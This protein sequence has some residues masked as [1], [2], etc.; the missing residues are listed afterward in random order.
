MR[1]SLLLIYRVFAFVAPDDC[2]QEGDQEEEELSLLQLKARRIEPTAGPV[3]PGA[4]LL[5]FWQGVFQTRCQVDW[6]DVPDGVKAGFESVEI[7]DAK[8]SRAT[9]IVP[10]PETGGG[11]TPS[12]LL[13]D[14]VPGNDSGLD[15][16]APVVSTA[17]LSDPERKDICDVF[18]DEVPRYTEVHAPTVADVTVQLHAYFKKICPSARLGANLLGNSHRGKAHAVDSG[19]GPE[20]V[21]ETMYV[22]SG[23]VWTT[24]GEP[25]SVTLHLE[26]NGTVLDSGIEQ[27]DSV[28]SAPPNETSSASKTRMGFSLLQLR[29]NQRLSRAEPVAEEEDEGEM[30]ASAQAINKESE[31]EEELET[32]AMYCAPPPAGG[33][34]QLLLA[35]PAT[36]PPLCC[37]CDSCETPEECQG[38]EPDAKQVSLAARAGASA[39]SRPATAS[40]GSVDARRAPRRVAARKGASFWRTP[41]KAWGRRQAEQATGDLFSGT[42]LVHR[43]AED[44]A[45]V[46]SQSRALVA[47]VTEE[48]G[49]IPD[50]FTFHEVGKAESCWMPP[51]DQGTCGSCWSF[52]SLGALEKQMCMRTHGEMVPSLSRE[53]LVR[54]SEQNRGCGGGTADKAYE[55][56]MEIG[57][58]LSTDC[59]PYQGGQGAKSCPS[60]QYSWF[61]GSKGKTGEM[62]RIDQEI[63]KSCPHPQRFTNRPPEGKEFDMPFR[64]MYES[65][66]NATPN[67]E[68]PRLQ[69]FRKNFAKA[70]A[71]DRVPSWWLY[72]EEAIKAALQKYGA[73]Y[74]SFMVHDDFTKG[75]CG[76]GCFPP[77]TIYGEVNQY[78]EAECPGKESGHAIQ[79]VGYGTEVDELGSRTKYWLIENSWGDLKHATLDNRGERSD[80][81]GF[82]PFEHAVGHEGDCL[83][84]G[85]AEAEA[86]P[87]DG[88]ILTVQVNGTDYV[89]QQVYPPCSADD[90]KPKLV[91]F[92]FFFTPA[93]GALNVSFL[94]SSGELLKDKGV[95]VERYLLHHVTMRCRGR[96]FKYSFT[97]ND[98]LASLDWGRKT[99][100][101]LRAETDAILLAASVSIE[102]RFADCPDECRTGPFSDTVPCLGGILTWSKAR[103]TYNDYISWYVERG[104]ATDCRRCNQNDM[105][106]KEKELAS[107]SLSDA[108]F[109]K[110]YSLLQEA[111]TAPDAPA[112]KR[113]VES[114]CSITADGFNNNTVM[115]ATYYID[116][117]AN[118]EGTCDERHSAP[119]SDGIFVNAPGPMSNG[120]AVNTSCPLG[121]SG[122][123]QLTCRDGVLTAVG[124]TCAARTLSGSEEATQRQRTCRSLST[125]ENCTGFCDFINGKCDFVTR[126]YFRMVRG[127]NYHD[128]ESGAA[129]AMA[130]TTNAANSCQTTGW[131]KWSDCS[132]LRACERGHQSRSR[133]PI[134]GVDRTSLV[135]T[136]VIF[137]E[138]RSCVGHGFCSDVLGRF[139]PRRGGNSDAAAHLATYKRMSIVLPFSQAGSHVFQSPYITCE[140]G[141]YWCRM[142]TGGEN[143]DM[144]FEG[145]FQVRKPGHYRIDFDVADGGG[146]LEFNSFG[147]AHKTKPGYLVKA[148]EGMFEWQDKGFHHR[149]RRTDSKPWQ[150]VDSAYLEPG[151]YYSRLL[152]TGWQDCPT[153]SLRLLPRSS[154]W[155][156]PLTAGNA[157]MFNVA[158]DENG[159]TAAVTAQWDDWDSRV[160]LG[161]SVQ[162]GY[163]NEL[164]VVKGWRGGLP[165]IKVNKT[166]FTADE[167]Y[168][169]FNISKQDPTSVWGSYESWYLLMR[170]TIVFPRRA[171]YQI[172]FKTDHTATAASASFRQSHRRRK[173]DVH[174]RSGGPGGVVHEDF[175]WKAS[176]TMQLEHFAEEPGTFQIE[177]N[178]LLPLDSVVTAVPAFP[179]FASVEVKEVDVSHLG[180]EGYNLPFGAVSSK[181]SDIEVLRGDGEAR[182]D[183]PDLDDPFSTETRVQTFKELPDDTFLLGR[184]GLNGFFL[185]AEGKVDAGACLSVE[186]RAEEATTFLGFAVDLCDVDG[187]NQFLRLALLEGDGV[188]PP[189]EDGSGGTTKKELGWVHTGFQ[190][191]M[192]IQVIRDPIH[193]EKFTVA[194][195]PD[196]RD[197]WSKAFTTAALAQA[198]AGFTGTMSVGG[199]MSSMESYRI[200]MFS[201]LTIETCAASCG[202]LE[203][204]LYCGKV[205]TPCD[206]ILDCPDTCGHGECHYGK[207]LQCDNVT[208]SP[209][210]QTWECGEVQQ[211]CLDAA[212]DVIR[213]FVPVGTAAPSVR[214]V[215]EGHE[216]YCPKPSKW[217]LLVEEG[218]E[219]GFVETDCGPVD[220]FDC[221]FG[222][223]VDNR[224]ECTPADFPGSY[225]CGWQ[226]D[227]CG[228]NVTFGSLFGHCAEGA[229]CNENSCCRPKTRDDFPDLQ[230]GQVSDGCGGVIKAMNAGGAYFTDR[231]D[232]DHGWVYKSNF[233]Y[234]YDVWIGFIFDMK[235]T[236][237]VGHLGRAVI[238]DFQDTL[239]V[240]LYN[241]NR[242]QLAKVTIGPGI[243]VDEQRYAYAALDDLVELQEGKRYMLLLRLKE[244]MKEQFLRYNEGV[245]PKDD[246]IAEYKGGVSTFWGD[247]IPN[248]MRAYI[249]EWHG[250]GLANFKVSQAECPAGQRC[251]AEGQCVAAEE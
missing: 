149:R 90:E 128:I 61:G 239:D 93:P 105:V 95:P 78:L 137:E 245:H 48:M 106:A 112:F 6:D 107:R 24:D 167:L 49:Q 66:F 120:A 151:N 36:T 247:D 195:R 200:A 220:L 168:N 99:R 150:A 216:W 164:R 21:P 67:P 159:M 69:R 191:P 44:H 236:T 45:L 162:E 87:G 38:E 15:G 74:G 246:K 104:W 217:A 92:K 85:W 41:H 249:S 234:S 47:E 12:R 110:W 140:D 125:A 166:S 10:V 205:V 79:I 43:T 81:W 172:R 71:R 183:W 28:F 160:Y 242:E 11:L 22:M 13:V 186:V 241:E 196:N 14:L 64:M 158:S 18:S 42:I 175:E 206:T 97:H 181:Q 124:S 91:P 212:G 178:T 75:F 63:L 102:E 230:C 29:G 240:A 219:C 194:Y 248:P 59:L 202:E 174:M 225:N 68:D 192:H 126:G 235:E 26:S 169:L 94:L 130:E 224:C 209:E 52:A 153:F 34:I 221:P 113:L 23:K 121:M 57:G 204:Q 190:N 72:G 1:L 143:C 46:W 148:N 136:D 89:R 70:R 77:G 37:L 32:E 223:C 208:L 250:V 88:F 7:V 213:E 185:H 177:V 9:A 226:S 201:N 144:L 251:S 147:D 25:M 4:A 229:I 8:A 197:V 237:A 51:Y 188:G 3:L 238:G 40:H 27:C 198:S 56:L 5:D 118:V 111:L 187:D 65:R 146:S 84:A 180:A 210:Q 115:R 16:W 233:W 135:C 86:P 244:G 182:V 232:A 31:K 193:L 100:M 131:T 119:F 228:T 62:A 161:Q 101:Q 156:P 55:D 141:N 80:A 96:G 214:H 103:C 176:T 20:G 98:T 139:I 134:E 108:D 243:P 60:M 53:M 189:P 123:V 2:D 76:D 207:C 203:A 122:E 82:N 138:T 109:V 142:L 211:D 30:H 114:G 117:P 170:H 152:R 231:A 222:I 133:Q 157:S 184:G 35:H 50:E 218:K 199:S 39:S 19:I 17:R 215:C 127:V 155:G 227:G 163:Q 179:N 116:M 54:C 129:F 58:V 132:A 83:V 165:P 145:Q 33:Y 73:L 173:V 154:R 171:L